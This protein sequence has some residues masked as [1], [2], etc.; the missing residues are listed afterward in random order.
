VQD[1]PGRKYHDEEAPT[2]S[3][4]CPHCKLT[5]VR[6]FILISVVTL[7]HNIVRCVVEICALER[8]VTQLDVVGMCCLKIYGLL[9]AIWH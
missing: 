5:T 3:V 9:T 6:V 7:R 2:L 4:R 1:S 8:R